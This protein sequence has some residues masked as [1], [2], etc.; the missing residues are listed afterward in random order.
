MNLAWRRAGSRVLEAV[1]RRYAMPRNSQ[2]QLGSFFLIDRVVLDGVSSI[3]RALLRHLCSHG[4][5]RT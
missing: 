4:V 5:D 2:F 1:L 3:P